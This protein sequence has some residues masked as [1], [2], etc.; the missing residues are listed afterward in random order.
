MHS[1]QEPQGTCFAGVQSGQLGSFE[2]QSTESHQGKLRPQDVHLLLPPNCMEMQVYIL[3]LQCCFYPAVDVLAQGP[4]F[5][6]LVK[7]TVPFFP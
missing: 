3:S 1:E 7:F 2:R 5:H 6:I 4:F